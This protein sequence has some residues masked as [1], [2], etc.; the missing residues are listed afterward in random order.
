MA[1]LDPQTNTTTADPFLIPDEVEETT[2]TST[3]TTPEP[4][5]TP[6]DEPIYDDNA[7]NATVDPLNNT[8]INVTNST[9]PCEQYKISMEIASDFYAYDFKI[10]CEISSPL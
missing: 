2:T 4:K 1:V 7:L 8:Q 6:I 9:I 10:Q 5:T 3:T